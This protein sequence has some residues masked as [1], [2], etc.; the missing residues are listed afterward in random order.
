M[1]IY[2]QNLK[3]LM[4]FLDNPSEVAISGGNQI[5]EQQEKMILLN[6]AVMMLLQKHIIEQTSA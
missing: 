1:E 4:S 2:K 6:E 3:I 5:R